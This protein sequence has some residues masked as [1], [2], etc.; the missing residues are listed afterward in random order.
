MKRSFLL[1]CVL[2]FA[3]CSRP[4]APANDGPLT[5]AACEAKGGTVVGDI[6]DGA[7]HKPDYRCPGTNAEPLGA[8]VAEPGAPQAVE[9]AVCCPSP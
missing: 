7:I 3:A 1:L 9:G 4:Q 8:I 6:G 2:L 5:A